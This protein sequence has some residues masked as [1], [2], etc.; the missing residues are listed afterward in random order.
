MRLGIL[1]A[2]AVVVAGISVQG[3]ASVGPNSS[4]IAPHLPPTPQ[5][6]DERTIRGRQQKWSSSSVPDSQWNSASVSQGNSET[7]YW[8]GRAPAVPLAVR[9]PYVSTW[10]S[11]ANGGSLNSQFPIFWDG[12]VLGWEGIVTVDDISY[13]WMG[14]GSKALPPLPNL[15]SATPVTT[16]YDSSYSNFTFAAGP[17][18][19]TASFFSSV[20]PQDLCRTSIPLSY[21]SVSVTPKDGN[22][23][24]VSLYTDV[25]GGWVTQPAAPLTWQIH[26][27]GNTFDT[28]NFTAQSDTIYTWAVQLRNQYVFGENHGRGQGI[29]PQWGDFVWSCSQ[30]TAKSINFQSGHSVAQRFSHVTGH[31]LTN[32][33]DPGFRS[34]TEQEPVFAFQHDLGD[35]PANT[36]TEPIVFTIGHITN[37]SIQLL[38]PKGLE[39]LEPWWSSC[40]A[41]DTL[42]LVKFHYRDLASAKQLADEFENKL[43]D[44]IAE[45]Y[46]SQ[47]PRPPVFDEN[48]V[49][50]EHFRANGSKDVLE[51]DQYD[52]SY[53]FDLG[54]AYGHLTLSTNNTCPVLN[55]IPP[56]NT[57]EQTSYYAITSLAT[58]QIL[59]AYV[60]TVPSRSSTTT[61]INA[62]E[63]P[64]P[65]AF[66]KEI[67]SN[68]NT[69]TVDIIYPAM[70][71]FLWINPD[72]LRYI[73]EPLYI[74]QEPGLYPNKYAAHDVGT[75]FPNATGHI[76]GSDESMPVEESGNMI[77]ITYAIHVFAGMTDTSYLRSH[78]DTLKQWAQ[79]LVDFSLIPASQLST[80]NFAGPLANQSS[81]A[82]KGIVGL[83]AMA[84]ISRL[85]NETESAELYDRTAREYYD[86]WS[87][88]AIDPTNTHTLLSYQWRS[89]WGLLYNIYPAL[90]LN[91]SIIP[92]SLYSMQC[93]FYPSVSQA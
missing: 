20:T 47:A 51:V 77:L 6:T 2:C 10:S 45:Y 37:P 60:L 69:N 5:S 31:A 38:S 49:S 83:A 73:L 13:E 80:D 8:P 84:E 23:H 82:I 76:D 70:P 15:I 88:L 85:L 63:S 54:N 65:L 52:K 78:Y 28:S 64:E 39:S 66:Q 35:V 71:F 53:I 29:F 9:S 57:S 55:G 67:S 91:P 21:L 27:D 17:V 1:I 48:D 89:S 72:F 92:S 24:K 62:Q 12:S 4:L 14:I 87:A 22:P 30:G 86:T 61:D 16:S 40:Y 33:V 75:H 93:T 59:A 43:K 81:L 56:P 46:A 34:Y 26:A 32:T 18:E 44:D 68:G 50:Y 7:T 42:D 11:T 90:L 74:Q 36:S 19:L 3:A 41:S 25:N 79:Y 58:R